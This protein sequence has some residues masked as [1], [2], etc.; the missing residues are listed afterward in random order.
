MRYSY[1]RALDELAQYAIGEGYKDVSYNHNETST[2]RWIHNSLNTPR[3]IRIEG[4]HTLENKTYLMLHELGHHLLRK[5][6]DKFKKRFPSSAYAEHIHLTDKVYKYRRRVSYIV[7]SLEEEYLAWDEG[8]KLAAKLG[9]KVNTEKF[10]LLK[11]KCLSSY[12]S[13]YANLKK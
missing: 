13:H 12:I 8:L 10:E 4:K 11:T 5:N 6:W 9:I 2:I 1:K 3:Y 7:A